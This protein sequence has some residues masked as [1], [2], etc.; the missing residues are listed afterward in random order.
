MAIVNLNIST[1]NPP[2]PT[3]LLKSGAL[4]SLGGTTLA[5]G[6]FQT[7][8]SETDLTAILSVKNIQSIVWEASSSGNNNVA[9][10]TLTENHG[11][12][13]GDPVHL[14]IAGV[15]PAAY[16]G[17]F[18]GTVISANAFT[19]PMATSPGA[20]TAFGT[21][22]LAAANELSQMN[23]SYWAQGT[24]RS[25]YV[26]E[27]GENTT[28]KAV[29]ALAA[30]IATDVSM[31]NT[32]QTF[33][34]YLVPRA[35]DT[36]PTFKTLCNLYTNPN[37]LVKF[38]V[39]TTISTY[40]AW[41]AGAYPN[42]YAGVEA[43]GIPAT[44]FSLAMH[45]QSALANDPGSSNQVPPMAFRFIYGATLYP[46]QG[47][48]AILKALEKANISYIGSAAEGGL[49]NMMICNGHMLDG[50]PFNYW[51][52]VAW[53]AINLELD[54]ANE[55]INGSNTTINPLYYEQPGIDRIQKRGLKTLRN[56]VSYGLILGPVKAE[57][58]N[59]DDFN[60]AYN[61]GSYDGMAVINAVPFT[62]YTSANESDYADGKYGGLSAVM[63][64]K[65]G[66][67]SITFNVNVTNF[68]G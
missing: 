11:W 37:N 1:T 53:T 26:L 19:I 45:F 3:A 40:Q 46:I 25:V 4:I 27:L 38:F 48:A 57:K 59:Q 50:K 39:T 65:R 56:G 36:E 47:N 16:N 43:P 14:S 8:Y 30:F 66:F 7:L 9:L 51:Y 62:D 29:A 60:A 24:S 31:G 2:K 34:I 22:T 58:Q 61:D 17:S 18:V 6:S 33:F 21:V 28:P 15:T 5:P 63:T 44:E 32:Y 52:S 54:I 35:W 23:T 10:I 20:I 42:V 67:E 49:S 68:V 13:I 64:P 55:V 41:V 12:N